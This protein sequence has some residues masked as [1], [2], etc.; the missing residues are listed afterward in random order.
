MTYPTAESWIRVSVYRR[1]G[2]IRS[3][4]SVPCG[5]QCLV[6]RCVK[7]P[8]ICVTRENSP[9][10]WKIDSRCVRNGGHHCL[11]RFRHVLGRGPLSETFVATAVHAHSSIAPRLPA[12]PVDQCGSVGSVVLV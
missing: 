4:A 3:S 11:Q 5:V 2:P 12:D 10:H 8:R 6:V 7:R 1:E 9:V